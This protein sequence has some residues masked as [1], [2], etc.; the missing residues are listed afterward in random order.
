MNKN[1]ISSYTVYQHKH[2]KNPVYKSVSPKGK[3]LIDDFLNDDSLPKEFKNSNLEGTKFATER[4]IMIPL[5][6]FFLPGKK[7][8]FI[9]L[10]VE[11]NQIQNS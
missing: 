1:N 8:K 7:N 10:M 2:Y 11:I 9:K 4:V 6:Q 3:T 5:I